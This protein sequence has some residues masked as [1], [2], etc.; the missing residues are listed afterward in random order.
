MSTKA[1]ILAALAFRLEG[2]KIVNGYG[3]DV[4]KVYVDDIPMGT[5]LNEY[6]LPAILLLDKDDSLSTEQSKLVGQWRVTLQLW[7]VATSDSVMLAFVR[8]VYKAIFAGSAVAQQTGAFRSLNPKIVEVKPVSIAS[9]L[10]MIE[11]NR[12][13][14]VTFLVHYRADLW[15]I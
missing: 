1:E 3:T 13:Y 5:Q 10:H 14:E 4:K 15:N 9:D 6:E 8:D 2:I 7:N 11:A 12:I